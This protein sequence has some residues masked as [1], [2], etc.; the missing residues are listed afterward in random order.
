VTITVAHAAAGARKVHLTDDHSSF[1]QHIVLDYLNKL[2]KTSAEYTKGK[3]AF[4]AL[5]SSQV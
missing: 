4:A 1:L 5:A 3:A 2:D